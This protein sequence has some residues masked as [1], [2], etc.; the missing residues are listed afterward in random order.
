MPGA[1]IAAYRQDAMPRAALPAAGSD[2]LACCLLDA[3]PVRAFVVDAR[4]V[5]RL[6]S[7]AGTES[8]RR[9]GSG[10]TILPA[11][12]GEAMGML[13][14]RQHEDAAV[15]RRLIAA[16]AEGGAGGSLRLHAGHEDTAPDTMQIVVVAPLGGANA[17]S[18]LALVKIEDLVHHAAPPAALLCDLFG[19]SAAEAEV[20][21][22]LV[23]GA[24]AEDVAHTRT[25]SVETVRGQIRA[26]LRKSEAANLRSFEHMMATLAAIGADA[27]SSRPRAASRMT[28]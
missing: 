18:G 6:S 10:I 14:A 13:M 23:G 20:A 27:A 8:L 15:L 9:P 25:V 26:I 5:V 19:F 11:A 1:A 7:V 21:L 2:P 4:A 17:G 12:P 3:M 28:A 16:A 24:S 22:G